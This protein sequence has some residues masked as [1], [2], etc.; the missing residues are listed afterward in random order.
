MI[1]STWNNDDNVSGLE[2]DCNNLKQILI[3]KTMDAEALELHTL[4]EAHH[5]PEWAQ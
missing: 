3:T 1:G 2:E 4:S 5:R